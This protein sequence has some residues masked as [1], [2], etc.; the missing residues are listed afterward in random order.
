M[1]NWIEAF[2]GEV[3]RRLERDYLSK[4]RKVLETLSPEEV[5][6][7]PNERSNAIGNL[8]LHLAGNVRQWIVSG[9]GGAPDVR[10]RDLEFARREPLGNG[11]LLRLLEGTV[12]EALEAV[13]E[14]PDDAWFAPRTIQGYAETNFSAVFHAVEHFSGHV[15]QIL[16]LAKLCQPDLPGFYGRDGSG[17]A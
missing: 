1:T 11:E 13:D 4:I 10:E 5:W 8:I 3:H 17:G 2:R 15:G 12:R 7:R 9:V 16:F 6:W 14:V